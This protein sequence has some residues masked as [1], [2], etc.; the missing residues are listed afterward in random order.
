MTKTTINGMTI[1]H[2]VPVLGIGVGESVAVL[3]SIYAQRASLQTI[4]PPSLSGE[5][6]EAPWERL[7]SMNGCMGNSGPSKEELANGVVPYTCLNITAPSG[8]SDLHPHPRTIENTIA[9]EVA[10]LRWPT[11]EHG[12]EFYARVWALLRGA[13]FP[14]KG[15]WSRHT[16]EITK[17][18][19]QEMRLWDDK[20]FTEPIRTLALKD[21]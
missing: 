11:L 2:D 1:W 8:F 3:I 21:R 15:G 7:H 19:R 9:H 12:A 4:P 13:Q 20:L 16:M 6:W 5:G 18:A 17:Q 10:H 14:P